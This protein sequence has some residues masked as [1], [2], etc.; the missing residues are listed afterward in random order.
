MSV[1][2]YARSVHAFT[3]DVH[4]AQRTKLPDGRLHLSNARRL[5][6][7]H[8]ESA[9]ECS[10]ISIETSLCQTA[11]PR[12]AVLRTWCRPPKSSTGSSRRPCRFYSTGPPAI[13]N[14]FCGKPA[15]GATMSRMRN[16]CCAGER[17]ISSNF[18]LAGRSEVP[19]RP[20]F[21]LDSIVAKQHSRP[22]PFCYHP[23]LLTP[24]GRF[25]DGLGGARSDQP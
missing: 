19:C 23:D 22:E 4:S 13:R 16:L 5:R 6:W 8:N 3:N 1:M 10:H 12:W 9:S 2:P 17:N 11:Q 18:S 15:S 14:G 25:L 21:L 24:L 20:L 7:R